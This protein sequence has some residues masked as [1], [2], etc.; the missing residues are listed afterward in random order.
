MYGGHRADAQRAS[1]GAEHSCRAVAYAPLDGI[2]E[3]DSGSERWK[4]RTAV[5]CGHPEVKGHTE[6][7]ETTEIF[8][9]TRIARMTRIIYKV[10]QI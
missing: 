7:T 2:R 10:P 6:I 3:C 5:G 4:V 9:R 8:G 1:S